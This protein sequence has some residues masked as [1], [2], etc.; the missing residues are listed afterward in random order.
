MAFLRLIVNLKLL[1]TIFH[2][3]LSKCIELF[4]LMIVLVMILKILVMYIWTICYNKSDIIKN[5]F[6]TCRW[7]FM[8]KY[9]V[10]MEFLQQSKLLSKYMNIITKWASQLPPQ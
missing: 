3:I 6:L 10:Y 4:F 1:E 9:V 8:N 2:N 5:H 7:V